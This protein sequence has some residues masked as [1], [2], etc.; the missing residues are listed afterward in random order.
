L[1][2]LIFHCFTLNQHHKTIWSDKIFE[3]KK[4]FI[5]ARLKKNETTK[6]GVE[7]FNNWFATDGIEEKKSTFRYSHSQFLCFLNFTSILTLYGNFLCFYDCTS[8]TTKYFFIIGGIEVKSKE[9]INH[10]VLLLNFFRKHMF[11]VYRKLHTKKTTDRK[12][13]RQLRKS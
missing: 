8:N 13:L 5:F 7:T 1:H 2:T 12:S 9:W 4:Y 3:Y 6:K 11:T 10:Q